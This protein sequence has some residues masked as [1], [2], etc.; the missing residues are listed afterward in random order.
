MLRVLDGRSLRDHRGVGGRGPWPC[1]DNGAVSEPEPAPGIHRD[2]WGVPRVVGRD[3]EDTARLQ[4][5]ATATDRTWQLE[6]VRRRATGRTAE[7]VGRPGLEWDTFVV[8]AGVE[9]LAR[10]AFAA[11]SE[12]TRCFVAAYVAGVNEALP[13]AT[14]PEL[15]HLGATA[16]PWQDWTPLAVF[17]AQHLLFGTL[18]LKLWRRHARQVLGEERARLLGPEVL[19]SSGSNSWVVGG[20]RT[21]SGLPLLAGDPHRSFEDPNGYVQVRLTCPAEGVDVAGFTFPGVPGVQHFAHAGEVAWG[22]TNAMGDYQDAYVEQLEGDGSGSVRSREA[23]GWTEAQVRTERIQVR[24]EKPVEV[25]VVRTARGPVVLEDSSGTS[26][27]LRR[28][29]EVLGDLGFD[30]LVPLLRA[31]TADDVVAALAGWVEP[32]NN[33]L[34]ADRSGEIRQQVVGRV[35]RR[36]LAN[37]REPVPAWE[38]GHDWDGWEQL[39]GRHVGPGEHLVTANHRMPG[40]DVVGV[41]FAPPARAHRIEQLLDGRSGLTVADCADIHGDVLAGQPASLLDAMRCLKGLAA[42]AQRLRDDLLGWDQRFDADSELAASYVAVR[43]AFVRRLAAEPELAELDRS[44]YPSLL[45]PWMSLEVTLYLQLARV[46]TPDGLALVPRRDEVLRAALADA[47][48]ARGDRWGERLRYEP[49][50]ALDRAGLRDR[51][52]GPAMSGDNDCVRCAGKVPGVQGAVRGSVAR[53]AWDL[54]GQHRSGWVVPAGASGDPGSPHHHDQQQA[55]LDA[56]LLGV[57]GMELVTPE[58][59]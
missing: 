21:R 30:C 25:T 28:P 2:R 47:A 48:A 29:S 52:R 18:P 15:D 50:H 16:E 24:G 13:G 55:W 8:R 17:A 46:F 57:T 33:L 26:I 22:I 3:L 51:T 6:H 14:C 45:D 4:G 11:C 9:P 34:A 20:S 36:A 1:S 53:Y 35:P 44:P 56:R 41:D 39:P 40:F 54:A 58:T 59:D 23:D 31:R 27:S 42:E 12:E 19:E 43:E 49:P 38:P 5:L 32:V 10:Q 7:L 37:R